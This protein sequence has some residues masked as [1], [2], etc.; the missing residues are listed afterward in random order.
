[1]NEELNENLLI[2]EEEPSNGDMMLPN[3]YDS[4]LSFSFEPK[5]LANNTANSAM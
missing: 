1:M 5:I 4:F 3:K 2:E